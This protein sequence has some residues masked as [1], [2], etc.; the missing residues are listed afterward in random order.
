[1]FKDKNVQ[2]INI[3]QYDKQLKIDNQILKDDQ[4]QKTEHTSF[5]ID[6][7]LSDDSISKL[8]IL[9]KDINKTF[10]ITICESLNQ[11][12]VKSEDFHDNDYEIRKLNTTYSIAI[13]KVDIENKK[14][15]FDK[16]GIDYIFSPFTILYNNIISNNANANSLNILILNNTI[17]AFILDDKKRIVFSA[18]K[19]L[20]AFND[21]QDSEFSSDDLDG[22]KLFDEMHTLEI[23]N[24]ITTITSEF[25][26]QNNSD[27]FCESVSILYTIKQLTQEQLQTIQDTIML[28]VEYLSLDLNNN[29]FSLSKQVTASRSSFSKPRE[30]KNKKSFLIWAIGAIATTLLVALVVFFIQEQIEEDKVQSKKEKAAKVLADKL[31]KD[32]KI[33]LPNH[34]TSNAKVSKVILS[35]LDIIPYNSVLSELQLQKKD[36][37]LVCNFLKEDTYEKNIKPKLLKLYKKSE[38]LLVQ[39]NKP[40]FNAIILNSGLLPQKLSTKEVQPNYRKNKFVA[41][42]TLIE[43]LQAFLPKNS[44]VEFRSKYKSK[45]LTYNFNVTTLFKEPIEFFNFV[46]ELD[47]KSYAIIVK[48]PI[49]FAQ[50]KKGLETTFN[51]QFHQ[52][53]KK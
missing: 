27:T 15:F 46:E 36:S 3:K 8:N 41:K 44:K 22:Q 12:I 14:D 17:Y 30:K 11:Q 51:L 53:H 43:Q 6:D 34:R 4:L 35:I 31:V 21:V 10:L 49:E 9:Q 2:Y 40:V 7:K 24:L 33:K 28:E 20:T 25:Y 48:Y 5:L 26:A 47:K 13:P 1:M 45:F 19:T 42:S 18:L 38:T 52:F 37:T 32:A 39:E 23:Q 16:T 29:L 50:T